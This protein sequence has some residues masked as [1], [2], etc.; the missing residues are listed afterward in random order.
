MCGTTDTSRFGRCRRYGYQRKC[1][2]CATKYMR[3]WRARRDSERQSDPEFQKKV[4]VRSRVNMRRYRS[5][6]PRQPC[7]L[8]G[9]PNG[10][11]HHDGYDQPLEIRWLCS[12]CH[13]SHHYPEATAKAEKIVEKA[14]N[15]EAL[16][17]KYSN[18]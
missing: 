12:R 4:R 10:E 8:C 7:E 9:A 2:D 3:E 18:R 17:K 6:A 11:A 15:F 1:R 14:R 16:A 5:G 13:G